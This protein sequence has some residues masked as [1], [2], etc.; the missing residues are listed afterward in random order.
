M[1][2]FLPGT[3]SL[4]EEIDKKLLVVLRDGRRL[5]GILRTFDQ[6]ANIVLEDTYERIFMDDTYGEKAVGLYLIRGE[7]VVLLG[8]VDVD[9]EEE[10]L[11]TKLKKVPFPE[12]EKRYNDDL[13]AKEEQAKQK[14]KM[15]Q[16]HGIAIDPFTFADNLLSFE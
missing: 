14:R 15:L 13:Q 7:N 16:E 5:V 10:I 2:E 9:K 6:F 12:I 1:N 4:V 3:A 8:E 11:K